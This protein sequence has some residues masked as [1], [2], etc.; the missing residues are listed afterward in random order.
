MLIQ[1][2]FA[3]MQSSA[4]LDTYVREKLDKALKAL[5]P[6][7]TRVVVHLRDDDSAHKTGKH[8]KRCTMEV[9]IAGRSPLAII[10]RENDMYRAVAVA[11]DKL[12]GAVR[13]AH[14]R[15]TER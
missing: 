14:D 4:P 2:N 1:V 11:A 8:D 7:I 10:H 15:R 5:R 3:D 13:R 9:R 12:A 6:H